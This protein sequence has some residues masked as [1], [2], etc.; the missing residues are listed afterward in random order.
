VQR[1]FCWVSG[2]VFALNFNG[3]LMAETAAVGLLIGRS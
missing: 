2:A 1:V 3:W